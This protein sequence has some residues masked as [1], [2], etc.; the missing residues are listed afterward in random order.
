M[1]SLDNEGLS[2]DDSH[3]NACKGDDLCSLEAVCA[4]VAELMAH[5]LTANGLERQPWFP[6]T[7]YI[8]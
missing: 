7:F 6:K 3:L 2:R 1:H 5:P 4:T 8:L